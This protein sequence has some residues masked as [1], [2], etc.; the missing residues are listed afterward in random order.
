MTPLDIQQL[1]I[2]LFKYTGMKAESPVGGIKTFCHK[3][4]ANTPQNMLH[5]EGKIIFANH[6][7]SNLW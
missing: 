4:V 1:K 6:G 5:P 3:G 7:E 2:R